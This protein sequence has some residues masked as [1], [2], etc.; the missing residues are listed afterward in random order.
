MINCLHDGPS[1]GTA[2]QLDGD[3]VW[4]LATVDG[5]NDGIMGIPMAV[6]GKFQRFNAAFNTNLTPTP[7]VITVPAAAWLFGSGLLGMLGVA[8]RRKRNR[9]N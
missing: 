5:N 1:F 7:K 4:M 8:R 6:G 9:G 2:G 3:S